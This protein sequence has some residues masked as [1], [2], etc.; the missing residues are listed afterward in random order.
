MAVPTLVKN[1][2]QVK[3]GPGLIVYA[4][5]GTTVPT[6]AA[7]ASK[8]SNS[9]VGWLPV[10]YTDEGLTVTFGRESEDV[11]VAEE[12]YPIRKVGTSA[13]VSLSFAASGVNEGVFSIAMA[14][15]TWSTVSG[16][17]ATLV[18]KFSPPDPSTQKRYMYGFLG[19]DTDEAMIVYQGYNTGEIT[20]NFRKGAEKSSFSGFVVEG[21]VPDPLVSTDVWN[22]WLAGAGYG[23]PTAYA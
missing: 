3:T 21:E 14:G 20:R 10:G 5:M 7:T 16:A 6:F 2:T 11:T 8:F 15:G 4:E 9:W 12:L 19:Q 1:P 13:T 23:L 22:H 17:G 18:R